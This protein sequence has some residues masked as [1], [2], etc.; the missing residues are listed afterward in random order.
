[1]ADSKAVNPFDL[2]KATSS[3]SASSSLVK[4][5]VSTNSNAKSESIL[6]FAPEVD[7]SLLKEVAPLDSMLLLGLKIAFGVISG[8]SVLSIVFF[9]SQLTDKFDFANS[10]VDFPNVSQQLVTSNSEIVSLKTDLNFYKYLQIKAHFDEFSYF[11]DSYLQ[12]HEILKSQTAEESDKKTAKKTMEVSRPELKKAFLAVREQLMLPLEA[13]VSNP[14]L[15]EGRSEALL[16]TTQLSNKFMEKSNELSGSKDKEAIRQSKNYL[17]AVK[18]VGNSALTNEIVSA[19]FDAMDDKQLYDFVKT[20]NSLIVNDLSVMQ[21]IKD[22]RIKWS[23]VMNEIELRTIAV[24]KHYDENL[25]EQIG[26][27]RYTSYDFD[28]DS[29]RISITGETKKIGTTNFSLIAEL[30]DELNASDLFGNASMNSFSKSGSLEEGY[31]ANLK[32]DLDLKEE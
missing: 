3:N 17:Q 21:E 19:D 12:G 23:D 18:L 5:I 29:S 10:F 2:N 7:M 28:G 24:D 26:G 15:L 32:L 4:G 20:V 1:M 25:Y 30:I 31:T 14:K 11:G 6:D 16:F 27:I 8:L 22:K 13:K 9:T